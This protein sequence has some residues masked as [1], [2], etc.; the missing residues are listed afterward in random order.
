MRLG[1]DIDGVLA[2]FTYPAAAL[3]SQMFG[4]NVS[5]HA[6]HWNWMR[7]YGLVGEQE[8]AYWKALATMPEWW[9]N[10]PILP[11][12]VDVLPRLNYLAQT[13]A[14]DVYFITTRPGAGVKLAT[15]R[16]LQRH[17]MSTPCVLLSKYKGPVAQGLEL[18]VFADD[19]PE[20]CVDVLPHAKHTFLIARPWNLD[21]E[22]PDGLRVARSL[23]DV[24][25][26][27]GL[28]EA[29]AA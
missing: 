24:L 16:W 21:Y 26:Q 28:L 22:R 13:G 1:I 15:E 29:V 20:N 7:D 19:R 4:L 12:A 8:S 10:L 5:G 2:D 3:A 23:T 25:A 17:G 18:D 14:A 11:D 6:T 9:G 27:V